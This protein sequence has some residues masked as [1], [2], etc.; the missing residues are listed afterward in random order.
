ML[1]L[2]GSI[3]C[4]GRADLEAEDA[5]FE[6]VLTVLSGYPESDITI[7]G[8]TDSLGAEAFSYNLSQR[9]ADSVKVYLIAHGI[10]TQRLTA[11]GKGDSRPVA[12]NHNAAGR[13][14]NSRIEIIVHNASPTAAVRSSSGTGN[15]LC[16]AEPRVPIE[17]SE[18]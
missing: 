8:H 6:R 7:E 11:V 3:F 10:I 15:A 4:K 18:E 12:G 17:Y 1:T 9:R 16:P 13:R 14:R 5:V 2:R